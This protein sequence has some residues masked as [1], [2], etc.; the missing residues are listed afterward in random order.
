MISACKK[1]EHKFNYARLD[2]EFCI[3]N[4]QIYLLQVRFLPLANNKRVKI[5]L[6][7]PLINIKKKIIKLFKINPTL[8][9][10]KTAFSNMSDWNQ[11]K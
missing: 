2:I 5:K 6:D 9:G 1:L 11:L 4:N 8:S 3:K 10:K 7:Q